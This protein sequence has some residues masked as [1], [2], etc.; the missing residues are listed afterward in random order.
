MGLDEAS[1]VW[2]VSNLSCRAAG[3]CRVP[4][5]WRRA[6]TLHEDSAG[7]PPV[8]RRGRR[9]WPALERSSRS[10]ASPFQALASQDLPC[11]RRGGGSVARRP[12][13]I[14]VG[15]CR[16]RRSGRNGEDLPDA[17]STRAR[18]GSRSESGWRQAW[19]GR[20]RLLAGDPYGIP[21]PAFSAGCKDAL[22]LVMECRPCGGPGRPRGLRSSARKNV[23][24]LWL[25]PA[26]GSNDRGCACDRRSG[27]GTEN[28]AGAA[29]GLLRGVPQCGIR[30]GRRRLGP[31]SGV[32]AA[33]RG[34]WTHPRDG[35][36]CVRAA[37]RSR[38]PRRLRAVAR[39]CGTQ[40][41]RG[42][43]RR[44]CAF[45]LPARAA[46]TCRWRAFAWQEH[47]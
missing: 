12:S 47:T 16:P 45:A 46:D 23:G 44:P 14:G 19:T 37:C 17:S 15:R 36:A 9:R 10:H 40:R 35:V 11:L 22:V 5:S 33:W 13:D 42:R 24:A 3:T 1:G 39:P 27:S 18:G 34:R 32:V 38:V 29:A 25:T 20:E 28:R 31:R 8:V 4:P 6:S 41:A 21:L 2:G 30:C 7:V 26:R 43:H